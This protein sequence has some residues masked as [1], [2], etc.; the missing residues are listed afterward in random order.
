M[1]VRLISKVRGM[2][3]AVRVTTSTLALID[4]MDSLWATPKRC[5]SSTTNSPRS[6]KATSP[7]KSRWVPMTT[8]TDPSASPLTTLRTW[9]GDKNRLSASTRIG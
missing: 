7:D 3:V 9:P 5:S 4:L 8:S 2:G 6:R 1:P